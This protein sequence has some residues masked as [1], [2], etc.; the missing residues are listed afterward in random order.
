MVMLFDLKPKEM[1]KDF[2]NYKEELDLFV[3]GLTDKSTR[4]IV[5]RG[6]RRTGKS[7]LLRV[8]LHKAKVKHV[9][10]DVRELTTLSRKS[11]EYKLLE[12]LKSI[13]GLPASLLE[14]IESVEMGVKISVKNEE[15]VWNTLKEVNPII[16]VDE[17][18]MLKG[19]G[20]EAFFAAAY[21]N[22]DCKI[23][24]TGSEVGVLD[25]F[26]GKDNPKASL[27]GR[28]FSEIKMHALTPE[29]SK[30][31]LITGFKEASKE[32]SEKETFNAQQELGGIV[33]WLTIFGNTAL[34]LNMK[35][36]LKKSV[37]EGS[38]LAYSELESF[39]DMRKPAK[40]RYL[41]LLQ[42]LAEREMRWIDLKRSLQIE[43][44]ESISDPQFSN[45]LNSLKDY[46]FI[47]LTDNI[48]SI[49][50]PLLKKALRGGISNL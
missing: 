42:L 26:V 39:L 21:D 8:G 20:V 31:F 15:K 34:S 22:T 27:F 24:L 40:K 5:I 32:I 28:V 46:G 19:T 49:P 12:E 23:V 50:D 29:K 3:R 2:F 11:F 41:A 48:Y 43:L 13:K 14:K 37:K 18:Q 17:V 47:I 9:L 16:A 36:A 30:E 7:S 45:Y 10:I 4:M 6:L 38:M 25:A 44:K 1:I 33:G 35:E